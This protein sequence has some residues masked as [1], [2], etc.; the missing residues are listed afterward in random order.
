MGAAGIAALTATEPAAPTAPDKHL[1]K[2]RS[3]GER[4]ALS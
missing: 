4:R 1:N 3:V 2:S